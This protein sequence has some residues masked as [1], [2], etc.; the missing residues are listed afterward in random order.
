MDGVK[1]ELR[2]WLGEDAVGR[3]EEGGK[4]MNVEY[5][6]IETRGIWGT[7]PA[8]SLGNS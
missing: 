8:P 5:R 6:G 7:P 3:C 1:D 4:Q 2:S